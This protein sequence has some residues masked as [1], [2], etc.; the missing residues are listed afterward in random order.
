MLA[1]LK[2]AADEHMGYT[3]EPWCPW[4]LIGRRPHGGWWTPRPPRS[5]TAPWP[6]VLVWYDNEA[7]F[8]NQLLRLI[9]LAGSML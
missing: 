4:I 6:R 5:W 8:T 3:D 7:G 9:K 1:V 2:A